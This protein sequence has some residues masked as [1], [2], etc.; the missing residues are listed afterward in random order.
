[1]S[2]EILRCKLNLLI[3]LKFFFFKK[4]SY[5][6]GERATIERNKKNGGHLNGLN[7]GNNN[8]NNN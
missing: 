2:K 7:L 5:E 4:K 8:N 1:M 3:I 6:N